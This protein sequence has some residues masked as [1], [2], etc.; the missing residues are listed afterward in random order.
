MGA[1]CDEESRS[2]ARCAER[3]FLAQANKQDEI[4]DLTLREALG[5]HCRSYE[6]LTPWP[7]D[8]R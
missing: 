5:E 3:G 8:F 1:V 4:L 6:L 7:E 2:S